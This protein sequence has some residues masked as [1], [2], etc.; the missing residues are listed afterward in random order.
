MTNAEHIF[1]WGMSDALSYQEAKDFHEN[2]NMSGMRAVRATDWAK[3]VFYRAITARDIRQQYNP[4]DI[5]D[6]AKLL[7]LWEGPQ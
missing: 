6:A 1:E 7:V 5:L 4:I 3:R 2:V